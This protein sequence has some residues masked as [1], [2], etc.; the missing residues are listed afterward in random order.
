[1][2]S[3]HSAEVEAIEHNTTEIMHTVFVGPNQI[4]EIVDVESSSKARDICVKI[5]KKLEMKSIEGFSLFV[6]ILDKVVSIKDN[7]FFFDY[8]RQL[9]D[10]LKRNQSGKYSY[11]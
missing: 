2:A 4:K 8:I 9:S 6:R 11:H 5:G 10:L 1:M 7:Q 3:L